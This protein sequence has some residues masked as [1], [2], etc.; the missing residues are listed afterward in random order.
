MCTV[1][2]LEIITMSP[3]GLLAHRRQHE[4]AQ[5]PR[6]ERVRAPHTLELGRLGVGDRLPAARDAGVV[7]EDVDLA[8]VGERAARPSARTAS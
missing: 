8:E 1:A 4:L 5:R 2:A 6:A 7:H 3:R